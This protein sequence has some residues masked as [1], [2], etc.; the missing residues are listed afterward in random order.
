VKILKTRDSPEPL[1]IRRL[2]I[3]REAN[4]CEFLNLSNPSNPYAFVQVEKLVITQGDISYRALKMPKYTVLISTASF[5]PEVIASQGRRLIAAVAFMHESGFIHMDIKA[6][7]IFVDGNGNWLLGDF[8]STCPVGSPV[9]SCTRCFCK[10]NVIG[11]NADPKFDWFMLL[12]AL[13]IE[14]LADRHS[15]S[16]HLY[17]SNSQFVSINK[18]NGLISNIKCVSLLTTINDIVFRLGPYL[19]D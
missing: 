11:I 16:E 8:G 3:E 6:S 2:E 18:L 14:T 15:F 19:S 13:I 12:V 1:D 9:T 5:N 17:D 4:I 7:N 10:E